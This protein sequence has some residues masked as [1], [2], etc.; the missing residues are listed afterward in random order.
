MGFCDL[1]SQALR[2]TPDELLNHLKSFRLDLKFTAGIWYFSPPNSRF[3]DLYQDP[4]GI[5]AR[6]EIA[7]RLKDYGLAGLEAHYPNEINDDNLEIW[8]QFVAG[9]GIR[10]VT[11]VPLLFWDEQFEWGSLSNPLPGDDWKG[12]V[13]LITEVLSRH[14]ERLDNHEA[15][16]CGSPGMIDAAIKV[17]KEKGLPDDRTFFDKF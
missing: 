9:T 7:A 3:H 4:R 16:L 10:L 11:I 6:L 15:Y 14:Y 17:F 2:R 5:E 13:G 12:E 1:R 8:R